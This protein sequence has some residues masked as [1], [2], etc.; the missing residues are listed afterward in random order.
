MKTQFDKLL[1]CGQGERNTTDKKLEIQLTYML[2]IQYL[3]IISVKNMHTYKE[4]ILEALK[5]TQ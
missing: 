1:Y 5:L 3:T 2:C 4:C